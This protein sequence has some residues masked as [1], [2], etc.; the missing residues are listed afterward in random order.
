MLSK[1]EYNRDNF[2]ISLANQG[3]GLFIMRFIADLHIHSKYSR[4]TSKDMD[5]ENLNKW[6][7][8]K[9]IKVLGTGDFTHPAWFKELREK[10]ELAEPGLFK[11]KKALNKERIRNNDWLPQ[12]GKTQHSGTRFL[13]TSEISCIYKK[14]D[15][16]RKIHLLVFAPD[17]KTVEKI[18]ARLG[19][20][21]NIKSDGRPILG[22]DAKELAKIVFNI[23]EKCMVIPAHCL[24]ADSYIHTD[25]GMAKINKIKEGD[26]VFT[27]GNNY[28][29]VNQIMKR[30]Y[31]GK[32]YHIKPYY[33]RLG[34]KTTEE[35][36]YYIIKSNKYCS[37]VGRANCRPSCSYIKSRKCSEEYYKKYKPEWV[38]AKNVEKGDF[39][40][41]P[42]FKNKIKDKNKILLNNFLDKKDYQINGKKIKLKSNRGKATDNVIKVNND[43]CRLMGYYLAEGYTDNRDSISFCFSSREKKYISDLIKLMDAVFGLKK[44]RSYKRGINKSREITFYSKILAKFFSRTFYSNFKNL[45]APFKRMPDWMLDLPAKKQIDIFRGW[46]RGDAG[47]TVSRELMNQ[48]KIILLRLGIIPSILINSSKKQ[49]RKTRRIGDRLIKANFDLYAFSGLTFFEDKYRL[50]KEKEFKKYNTK[51]MTRHGWIDKKYVYLPVRDIEVSDFRGEVYNLEVEKDNSYVLEFATVHNCWTPWFSVF[52][53]NSGFNSVEECFEELSQYIYAGETGLSSDPAMNWRWSALDKIALISN[54]DAHSPSKIGREANVFETDLSYQGITEAIKRRDKN[55]LIETIEFFPEEG[56][57]HYDGHRKCKLS[58]KPQEAKKLKNICPECGKPLTIGVYHR[59]DDLADCKEGR[60][61]EDFIP[62]RHLIPLDEII[63]EAK[64]VGPASKTVQQ[65]YK[66]LISR[67]GNEFNILLNTDTQAVRQAGCLEVAE[68]IDRVREGRV[69]VEPGYDGEYGKIK[70]FSD[71]DRDNFTQQTSLF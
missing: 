51:R 58:L 62:F 2:V 18:N 19:W 23:N 34:L 46:W 3:G 68:A 55:K 56:K 57:Y 28:R 38:Q 11:I 59:I 41:Y 69:I 65:A 14:N 5:V 45:R 1:R 35:H 50:L 49:L 47:Y 29:K 60:K 67:F 44:Y 54:S 30:N 24:P 25:K 64:G 66:E 53:S 15:F 70:I 40:I 31:K 21:G 33:F 52:G 61:P 27:H 26:R 42:R 71:Q 7:K 4:A 32:L 39:L 6:A 43:F 9:G 20:I 36:P 17:F 37:N 10:L 13:L 63:G 8:I 12:N 22:L 48:M 16:V